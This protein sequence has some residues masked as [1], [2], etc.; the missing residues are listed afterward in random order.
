MNDLEFSFVF[1]LILLSVPFLLISLFISI[2][3][4]VIYIYTEHP[5]FTDET[6]TK[7]WCYD[8]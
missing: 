6:K 2:F 8:E 3:K 4:R 7:S 1:D 5:H